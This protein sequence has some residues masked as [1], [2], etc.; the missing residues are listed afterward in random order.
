MSVQ[1]IC[2]E[3]TGL[4]TEPHALW[5]HHDVLDEHPQTPTPKHVP[6]RSD[7]PQRTRE[8]FRER[9]ADDLATDER[10]TQGRSK[11]GP[12]IVMHDL[13]LRS[14]GN[15]GYLVANPRELSYLRNQKWLSRAVWKRRGHI[16][17]SHDFK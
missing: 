3:T 11:K 12:N 17:D 13:S 7:R 8:G 2:V 14:H 1:M 10:Q 15:D 4:A 16:D 9:S 6:E 5:E